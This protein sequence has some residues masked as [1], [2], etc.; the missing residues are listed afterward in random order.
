MT[1]G[2]FIMSDAVKNDS[3]KTNAGE[4]PVKLS[5]VASGKRGRILIVDDE[6]TVCQ[7][8]AD[9]LQRCGHRVHVKTSSVEAL[10]AFRAGPN[11]YDMVITDQTMPY[12]TGLTLA[13]YLRQIKPDIS[14]ILCTGYTELI[15]AD[16]AAIF[17]IKKILMKPVAMKQLERVIEGSL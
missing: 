8:L 15:S 10:E 13:D 1:E 14:V 12:L 6:E 4:G 3:K 7:H 5:T 11:D 2:M 17:G 9:M 16:E